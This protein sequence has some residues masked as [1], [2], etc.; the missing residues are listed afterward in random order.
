MIL[1]GSAKFHPFG[2][3]DLVKAVEQGCIL[4]WNMSNE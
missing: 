4:D 1:A 3:L 2:P